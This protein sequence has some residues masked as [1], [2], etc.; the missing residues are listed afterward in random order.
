MGHAEYSGVPRNSHLAKT[1]FACDELAGFL[2]AV[3]LVKPSKSILDV[4]VAGVR[5]KLKDKAFA[6]AINRQDIVSGAEELGVDLDAHIA[7]CL[8]A[9]Q[10][11]A[12]ALGLEGTV[13]S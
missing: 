2:T 12:A 5:R 8:E 6:R 4:E 1:L 3:S 7:F 10:K 11:N 13:A 9:M